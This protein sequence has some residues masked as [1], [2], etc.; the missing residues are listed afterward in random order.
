MKTGNVSKILGT[1]LMIG[2]TITYGFDFDPQVVITGFGNAGASVTNATNVD[3]Y[4][5]IFKQKLSTV[6]TIAGIGQDVVFNEDTLAGLQ[7][8]T[9]IND[10]LS[11]TVQ[12]VSEGSNFYALETDWL[13]AEWR[14]NDEW[15]LKVGRTIIPI[16]MHSPYL[17]VNYAYVWS[18]LPIEFYNL[19][20]ADFDGIT[21]RHTW[22][23]WNNWKND[24]TVVVGNAN[25]I[26]TLKTPALPFEVDKGLVAEAAFYNENTRVRGSFARG[27]GQLAFPQ[28]VAIYE[29]VMQNPCAV[30][31]AELVPSEITLVPGPVAGTCQITHINSP[32]PFSPSQGLIVPDFEAAKLL[33]GKNVIIELYTLGYEYTWGHFIGSGEWG[34]V[35]VSDKYQLSWEQWYVM[36][37]YNWD[38]IT[39]HV[40]Y[41]SY[42]TQNDSSRVLTNTVAANYV[43]PFSYFGPLTP[44]PRPETFQQSVNEFL[45]LNNNSQSTIDVGIRYDIAPSTALKFDYRYVMP[46]NNTA[47]FFDVPPGKR[48]SWVTAVIAVV[49]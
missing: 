2:S 34:K 27:D 19:D 29:Q 28:Q 10:K 30:F 24:I 41:S 12:F 23:L 44:V 48:I 25:G 14:I 43:N 3:F 5:P 37:G 1:F 45:A 49:F 46:K 36:L 13:F 22:A 15:D 21:L 8:V 4:D 9:S 31:Q 40:T 42:R 38:K 20:F 47:G 39:P 26:D 16:Y 11:F 6:P 17:K 32:L 35:F 7:F 33:N 18:R